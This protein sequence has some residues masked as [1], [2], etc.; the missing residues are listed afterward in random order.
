M[1]GRIAEPAGQEARQGGHA[2]GRH[3]LGPLQ[4]LPEVLPH[5][6]HFAIHQFTIQQRLLGLLQFLFRAVEPLAQV[7]VEG[8]KGLG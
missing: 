3:L 5:P 4:P 7:T 8:T 1:K 2:A 6:H